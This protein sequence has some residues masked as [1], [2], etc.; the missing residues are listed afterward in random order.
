[1]IYKDNLDSEKPDTRKKKDITYFHG[2][3]SKSPKNHHYY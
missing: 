3:W 2:Q 1:M